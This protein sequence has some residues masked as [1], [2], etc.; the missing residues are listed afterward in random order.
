MGAKGATLNMMGATLRIP[1]I[2]AIPSPFN[3]MLAKSDTFRYEK[4]PVTGK[5]IQR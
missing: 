3:A 5:G 1:N 4:I 2:V